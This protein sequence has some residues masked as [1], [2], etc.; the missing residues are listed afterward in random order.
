MV[1]VKD[2]V[3]DSSSVDTAKDLDV[4]IAVW[5]G[6]IRRKTAIAG[7]W[8]RTLKEGC[9]NIITLEF[10]LVTEPSL[11]GLRVESSS[12]GPQGVRSLLST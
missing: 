9:G 6:K 4:G 10:E 1:F 7:N 12:H 3:G 11:D 8:E 5:F 2:P